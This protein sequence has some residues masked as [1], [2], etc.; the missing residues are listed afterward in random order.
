M[1]RRVFITVAETSGDRHAAQLVRSL[2]Q[3]DP[4]ILIEGFG[5]PEM[6]AAGATILRET[7][8]DAAMTLHG[9]KR[10]IEVSRLLKEASQYYQDTKPDLQ[11]CVDSSAMNLL[12]ARRAKEAKIPVL[13]YVA[14]QLWASRE[15]RMKKLRAYVDRLACILPFEEEYF[16]RHGVNATFVGHPLFDELP[17]DR[18]MTNGARFPDAPPVI[19]IVPG[20]RKTEVAANLRHLLDVAHNIEA[21]FPG[22][23]FLIPT[24]SATHRQV[25]ETAASDRTVIKEDAFDELLPQCDLCLCKSGTS[26]L[27]VAAHGVPMIVVYRV[28]RILWH[29]LGRWVIRT[30]KIALVNILAGQTDLVPEFIPWYGSNQP[31]VDCAIDMLKHPQKLVE[32]REKLNELVKTLDRRGASMNVARMATEMMG[33]VVHR[34]P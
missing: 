11:V 22:V 14:P 9:A 24:T 1:P 6:A 23:R 7:V 2:R 4:T 19:G 3:L 10:A 5:G 26:T 16:R 21:T 32:Q 18:S 29:I 33:G 17:R 30:R 31:V 25:V 27:H 28:S 12:F 15:G 20:S 34:P 13:Y 8:A